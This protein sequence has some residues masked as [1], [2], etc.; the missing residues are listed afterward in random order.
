MAPDSQPS[1]MQ[2]EY[3]LENHDWDMTLAAARELLSSGQQVQAERG[4]GHHLSY[5]TAAMLLAFCAFE[6]F[7][8]SLAFVAHRGGNTRLNYR[9]YTRLSSI[10]GRF[11]ALTKALGI[12]IEPSRQPFATLDQMRNWRNDMVHAKP[13]SVEPVPIQSPDRAREV[14]SSD[15]SY[16]ALVSRRHA[17]AFYRAAFV[18]IA[19]LRRASG[20]DA[21]THVSYRHLPSSETIRI[22]RQTRGVP[23]R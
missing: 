11:E 20:L 16:L 8:N 18:G 13:F 14:A 23:Q 7:I 1:S 3:Y 15:R 17:R 2:W 9:K 10:W 6:S 12:T 21:T 22:A 4:E 19:R 5:Y